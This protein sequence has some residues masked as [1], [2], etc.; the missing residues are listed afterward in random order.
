MMSQNVFWNM[1]LH[2]LFMYEITHIPNI[3]QTQC[4]TKD[5]IIKTTCISSMGV[6]IFHLGSFTRSKGPVQD[7][8]KI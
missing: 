3:F 7:F 4:Y 1:Q 6:C 2:T 5:G 8:T